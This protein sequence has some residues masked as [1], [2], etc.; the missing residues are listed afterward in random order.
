MRGWGGVRAAP[1]SLGVCVCVRARVRVRECACA[2]AS[3]A[4]ARSSAGGQES[5]AGAP[6][7]MIVSASPCAIKDAS[8]VPPTV[9]C[10]EHEPMKGLPYSRSSV[11]KGHGGLGSYPRFFFLGEAATPGQP[12]RADGRD[13]FLGLFFEFV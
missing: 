7:S 11:Y 12:A 13:Q 2:C 6:T 10:I 4:G 5:M 1:P 3:N 8:R 9:F